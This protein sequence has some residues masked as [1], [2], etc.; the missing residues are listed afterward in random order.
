MDL[1]EL[2]RGPLAWIA[3]L[4]FIL[5]S[6]G[7]VATVLFKTGQENAGIPSRNV[8]QGIRSIFHWILPFG[9]QEMRKRPDVT[10]ISFLFHICVVLVPIFLLAHTI[11]WYESW[12][13]QW[14]SPPETV[15]DIMTIVVIL[16]CFFFLFRRIKNPDVRNVTSASDYVLLAIVMLPFVTGF[17]AYH[18]WGPSR[19]MLIL[20]VLS[21]EILLVAIPF[22]RIGHMLLF[23][24]SRSEMGSD[25][26]HVIKPGDW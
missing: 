21:G 19:T 4:V 11:L 9:S 14:W 23:P 1:Y 16:S 3:L 18:Q 7:R 17:F 26:G 5:G 12:R 10:V 8:K 24:F 20:H 22:T 13:I 15:T 2:A 25:Y 6:I